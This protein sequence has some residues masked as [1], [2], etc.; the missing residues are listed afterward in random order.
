MEH[1]LVQGLDKLTEE[2]ILDKI[3]ELNKKLAIAA[4]TGNGF[5]ANQVRMA[6]ESYQN[7]YQS[8][9]REKNDNNE[10]PFLNRID[11]S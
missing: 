10:N 4:R 11:I 8:L 7:R 6:L 3:S 2:E 5:L 9:Q 1:P